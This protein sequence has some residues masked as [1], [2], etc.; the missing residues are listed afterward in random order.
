MQI[1]PLIRAVNR[2]R[3]VSV[4]AALIAVS[5][6]VCVGLAVTQQQ[7]P[8]MPPLTA[9]MPPTPASAA[10][11]P[12]VAAPSPRT[13]R[14]GVVP[15]R[16]RPAAD[17]PR[18]PARPASAAPSTVGPVLFASAPVS[19]A[20]P[21]IGVRSRLLSLGLTATGSLQVPLPG[22]QYNLAGWYRHSP[23]PGSLGPA[24]IA[25][26]VDS[27][28][29]GPSV[30]FRLGDLRPRDTVF[31]T[32]ADGSVA[33]FAVDAVYRFPKSHFPSQLVYGNTDHAA[34]RLITC[35]GPFDRAARSYL[36]NIVVMASLVRAS[37][38]PTA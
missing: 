10:V 7:H 11:P 2:P 21:V 3:P 12:P 32:R 9:A 15:S 34:L 28:A 5:G 36:D 26:H 35:G 16:Q 31:V 18:R 37:T 20:I 23:A 27:A 1:A 14:S 29:E 24:V 17:L 22:P 25:G 30:F 38:A 8:P 19:L 4:A 13:S 33:V 6:L